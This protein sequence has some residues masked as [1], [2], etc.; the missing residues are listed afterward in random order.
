MLTFLLEFPIALTTAELDYITYPSCDSKS[1]KAICEWVGTPC[2]LY[3]GI[4]TQ[5][6]TH[7]CIYIIV[8]LGLTINV[9]CVA[10]CVNIIPE[11]CLLVNDFVCL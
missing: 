4:L 10:M 7:M 2:P 9:I 3:R 11:Q 1:L 5:T 8:K 6:H